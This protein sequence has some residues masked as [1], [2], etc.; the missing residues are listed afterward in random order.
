ML[1]IAVLR[2]DSG[3]L[4]YMH[5]L[6]MCAGALASRHRKSIEM[7]DLRTSLSQ[8]LKIANSMRAKTLFLPEICSI[9]KIP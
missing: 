7:P 5:F 2:P 8:A 9:Y 3:K 6:H 4:P 1:E